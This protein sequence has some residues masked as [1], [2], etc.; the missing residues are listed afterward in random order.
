M[1]RRMSL[2]L[3][4]AGTAGKAVPFYL[5]NISK[6]DILYASRI[7][8]SK[9][10]ARRNTWTQS[11]RGTCLM[12]ETAFYILYCPQSPQHGYGINHGGLIPDGRGG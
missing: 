12:S 9:F 4:N 2:I 3:I 8:I 11:L 7:D 10:D 5:T 1:T 6:C